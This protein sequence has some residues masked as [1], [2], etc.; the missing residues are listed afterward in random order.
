MMDRLV[1]ADGG[2]RILIDAGRTRTRQGA[3]MK[4]WPYPR[5][6]AGR[7]SGWS[8]TGDS[9]RGNAARSLA[10]WPTDMS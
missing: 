1:C 5:H 3:R 10:D 8:F 4:G 2:I 6:L 9:W 7:H